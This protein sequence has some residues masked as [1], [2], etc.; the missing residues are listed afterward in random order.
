MA[1][2]SKDSFDNRN[3]PVTS[4]DRRNTEV[5]DEPGT[6]SGVSSVEAKDPDYPWL[7]ADHP[8]IT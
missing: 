7:I 5:L 8:A 2:R 6:W 1:D 3:D 4:I